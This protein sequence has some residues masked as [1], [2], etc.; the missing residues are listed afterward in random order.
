MLIVPALEYEKQRQD[1]TSWNKVILHR[2]GKFYRVYEWSLWLVKKFVCTEEFQ[3][4]RGDDKML[5]AKR[6]VGKKTGEYAMSGF[7]VESLSKYIPEYQSVRPMEGGDDLEVTINMPLKGDEKYE[8]LFAAFNEWKQK[9][10][11]YEPDEKKGGK[12]KDAKPR[13]G[14]FAIVQRLL[15]YPVE[16]KSSAENVEFI[17]ELKELAAELL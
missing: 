5:S 3:K 2:E 13:G 14:A 1:H 6:Y 11:I 12:G 7:P 16:K 15:S 8:E 4:Q 9:L 17:S 10:E